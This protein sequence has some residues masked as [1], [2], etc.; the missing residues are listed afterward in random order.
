MYEKWV[1]LYVLSICQDE[2]RWS[3]T[4]R[5]T[6]YLEV[7]SCDPFTLLQIKLVSLPRYQAIFSLGHRQVRHLFLMQHSK[8][9][10]NRYG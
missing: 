8:L 1:Y 7:A 3:N 10:H 9:N 6:G 5:V 4:K 2:L